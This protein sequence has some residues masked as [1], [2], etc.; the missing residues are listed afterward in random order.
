VT[1]P[2]EFKRKMQNMQVLHE[3]RDN[4]DDHFTNR[5]N[6][7]RKQGSGGGR[8]YVDDDLVGE[9]QE[10]ILEHLIE[11]KETQST[12]GVHAIAKC[13]AYAMKS[14]MYD[15]PA[16]HNQHRPPGGDNGQEKVQQAFDS[17]QENVWEQAYEQRCAQL[18]EQMS[19]KQN[20]AQPERAA[21][22]ND[23][24]HGDIDDGSDFRS[25]HNRNQ[26]S[27]DNDVEMTDYAGDFPQGD[28]QE[29]VVN[30][31]EVIEN[32]TLNTEQARVFRIIAEHSLK[33]KPTP[34][35][36]MLGG[37]GGTGKSRVIDAL[38]DFFK[39]RNQRGRM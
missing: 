3:C 4:R 1:C 7:V 6:R 23:T 2:V 15:P 30:L 16:S 17:Y 29:V 9:N 33:N 21:H 12:K 11:V 34:L 10:A 31:D 35:R 38:C 20:D 14:G 36:M 19:K 25:A 32:W 28:E 5:Q 39:R 18:K 37:P 8:S 27:D 26:W 13:L 24:Y 22:G